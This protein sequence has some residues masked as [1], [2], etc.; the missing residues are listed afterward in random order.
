LSAPNGGA[1]GYEITASYVCNS[2]LQLGVGI[3]NI[4]LE[5]RS[6]TNIGKYKQTF[7]GIWLGQ[8]F[9][10]SPQMNLAIG[11]IL[12]FAH[13]RAEV[14]S[15]TANGR[16]DENSFLIEPRIRMTYQFA[17]WLKAGVSV[18]YL[19]PLAQSVTVSG[20]SLSPGNISFHGASVGLDFV[21]GH[22]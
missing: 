16:T 19:E 18:S 8:G 12:G 2:G 14:L 17:S 6:G 13:A 10:L 21:L 7:D 20:Q 5:T 11:T 22:F 4:G 3:A 9:E 15:A 1:L